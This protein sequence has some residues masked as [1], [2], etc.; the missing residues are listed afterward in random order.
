MQKLARWWRRGDV[1]ADDSV[2]P[3]KLSFGANLV[4][5]SQYICIAILVLGAVVLRLISGGV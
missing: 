2:Q 4:L 5:Y 1:A 3:V